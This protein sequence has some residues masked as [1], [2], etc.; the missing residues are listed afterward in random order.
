MKK[1]P[2]MPG[3]GPGSPPS[4]PTSTAALGILRALDPFAAL[5]APTDKEHRSHRLHHDRHHSDEALHEEKKEKKGFWGGKEKEKEKGRE[6]RDDDGQAELT[7]MIGASNMFP[8][9]FGN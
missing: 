6:R 4:A 2:Q 5:D 9:T 1:R 3:T 8:D 7:R